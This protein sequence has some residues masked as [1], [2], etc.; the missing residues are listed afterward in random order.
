MDHLSHQPTNRPSTPCTHLRDPNN[1]NKYAPEITKEAEPAAKV[2][3]LVD[4]RG[5]GE[6]VGKYAYDTTN[7]LQKNN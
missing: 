2:R 7:P 6:V 1:E 5:E 3:S 4:K